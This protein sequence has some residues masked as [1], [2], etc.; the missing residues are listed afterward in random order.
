MTQQDRIFGFSALGFDLSVY[1]LFGSFAAGAA[2]VLPDAEAN[3]YV[4]QVRSVLPG[5]LSANPAIK[6]DFDALSSAAQRLK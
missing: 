6:A 2:L 5:L 4:E 3:A 1:D